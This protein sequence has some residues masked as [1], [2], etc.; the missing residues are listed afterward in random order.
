MPI[1]RNECSVYSHSPQFFIESGNWPFASPQRSNKGLYLTSSAIYL[2]GPA[3]NGLKLELQFAMRLSN[4]RTL[5][6][7]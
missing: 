3:F 2:A 1:R 7:R 4:R 6:Q 5:C